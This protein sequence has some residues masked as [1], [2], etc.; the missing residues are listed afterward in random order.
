MERKKISVVFCLVLIFLPFGLSAQRG[1]AKVKAYDNAVEAVSL[2]D[3]GKVD[4][5]I[6]LLE[7][8]CQLDPKNPDYPYE[9]GYAYYLK[10][11]YEKAVSIGA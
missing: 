3:N 9:L 8:S 10:E 6:A 1:E 4:E 5:S 2:M 11:D 7:E